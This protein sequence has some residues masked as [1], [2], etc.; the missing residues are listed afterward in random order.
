MDP[1]AFELLRAQLERLEEKVDK[2]LAFK[3][4]IIGGATFLSTLTT[5]VLNVAMFYLN[6]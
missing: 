4:Q 6:K 5:L 3:W 1:Q 2:L